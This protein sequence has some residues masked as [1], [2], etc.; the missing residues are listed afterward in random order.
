MKRKSNLE[1]FRANGIKIPAMTNAVEERTTRGKIKSTLEIISNVIS[2]TLGPYGSTTIIQNREYNNHFAT[3]DG[4]DL[5]NRMQFNDDVSRTVLDLVRNVA[6]SQ[7]QTVGDGSTS[8]IVIS[9]AFYNEIHNSEILKR[10]SPRD[11][12]DILNELSNILTEEVKDYATKVD[13]ELTQIEEIAAIST[14]NDSK[15]GKLIRDIYKEITS[16]GFITLDILENN[17]MED[18]YEIKQGVS[19]S[20]GYVDPV[21]D[22]KRAGKVTFDRDPII[23]LTNSVLTARDLEPLS[24]MIGNHALRESK[25]MVIVANDID[26]DVMNFFKL[27]VSQNNDLEVLV[28]GIDVVTEKSRNTLEDLALMSGATIYDKNI[29]QPEFLYKSENF[30]GKIEKIEATSR[31]TEI[32]TPNTEEA[33]ERVQ[34]KVM[35]LQEEIDKLIKKKSRTEK[36][37]F[38]IA[39][40]R[41][42]LSTLIGSTAILYIAGRTHQERV[43]RQRLLEDAVLSSRSA[44]INGIIPGG[45][46]IIPYLMFNKKEEL[47]NKLRKNYD[48]NIKDRDKIIEEVYRVFYNTFLVSYK[49]VLENAYF[50]DEQIRETITKCITEGKIYNLRTHEYE[51]MKETKVVNSAETDIRIMDS[52]VSLVGILA[53]SN[54]MI[55]V[56]MST[57]D[58]IED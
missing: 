55:T 58:L 39:E 50:N 6:S 35:E 46:L 17:T 28:V 13:D 18:Y 36:E 32:V 43:T 47:L 24:E 57:A 42:R 9:S 8:S 53:T 21:F 52:V 2:A 40:L 54:Q 14:N 23:F 5:M 37:E 49:R 19:W 11:I 27:N 30:L 41:L 48:I 45:N 29:H 10:T 33:R 51:D 15:L 16:N 25:Q 12:L 3:K 44:I 7:V 22:K 56:G 26:S 4:Y 20:Y 34:P 31:R 38:K 1:I